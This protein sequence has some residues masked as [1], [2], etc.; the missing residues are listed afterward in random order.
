MLCPLSWDWIDAATLSRV[1][2]YSAREEQTV[3]AAPKRNPPK[4]VSNAALVEQ[5]TL[6]AS[7][8][9]MIGEQQKVLSQALGP[10]VAPATADPAIAPLP[11]GNLGEQTSRCFEWLGFTSEHPQESRIFGWS[12]PQDKSTGD[13][14][15]E[16]D[17]FVGR[18]AKNYWGDSSRGI[19]HWGPGHAVYSNH[20]A[21]SPSDKWRRRHAR[22]VFFKQ[23]APFPFFSRSWSSGEDAGRTCQ[24]YLQLF[25]GSSTTVVS[26]DEPGKGCPKDTR[27]VGGGWCLYDRVPRTVRGIQK[28]KRCRAEL[29][30]CRPRYGL[31]RSWRLCGYK[32]VPGA[33]LCSIGAKCA[34][35]VVVVGL[36]SH[37]TRRSSGHALCRQDAASGGSWTSFCTTG[38][39]YV[40]SNIVGLPS[41]NRGPHYSEDGSE[42]H[43][44]STCKSISRSSREREDAFPPEATKVPQEAEGCPRSK[45]AMKH[46]SGFCM[47]AGGTQATFGGNVQDAAILHPPL[48]GGGR[49]TSMPSTTTPFQKSSTDGQLMSCPKWCAMLVSNV[50]KSRTPVASF[51]NKSIFFVPGQSTHWFGTD[52]LPDSGPSWWSLQ[53]D[54]CGSVST[55]E[56]DVPSQKGHPHHL[57]GFELLVWW[58]QLWW[59]GIFAEGAKCPTSMP[60]WSFG[61][62]NKVGRLDSALP[63]GKVGSKI[64]EFDCTSWWI[65]RC[66]DEVW[67]SR[68]LYQSLRG[69]WWLFGWWSSR[70]PEPISGFGSFSFGTTW[71]WKLGCYSFLVGWPGDGL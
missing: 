12:S 60:L 17:S 47:M 59:F 58:R 69:L 68:S 14:V 1:N 25:P 3:P 11:G 39:P 40:G 71:H 62:F 7:Q 23:S 38:A 53:S 16:A 48:P 20:C 46:G 18:R 31:C 13:S 43:K 22:S 55:E 65:V 28:C 56:A 42:D 52:L 5:L 45:G 19:H 6:L 64:P 54:A 24:P 30:G 36:D 33:S 35:R 49:P 27:G 50:L 4:K 57:Y 67:C 10:K 29:V 21:G 32:R 61:C 44:S 41:R 2:F 8:V 9:Q 63:C 15:G 51:L 37:S 26:P 34:R 70:K 66:F